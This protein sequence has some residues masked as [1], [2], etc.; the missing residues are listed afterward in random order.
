MILKICLVISITQNPLVETEEERVETNLNAA[1]AE[2]LRLLDA[3]I[4][5]PLDITLQTLGE[6]LEHGGASREHN[7]LVQ[8][9]TSVDGGALDHLVNDLWEG[10]E[11]VRAGNLGVEEDLRSEETLVANVH[12]EGLLLFSRQGNFEKLEEKRKR[13]RKEKKPSWSQTQLPRT[14]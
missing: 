8:T 10:S 12:S 7:V 9:T 4:N 14:A 5:G 3:V 2:D 13:K 6:I 11:E 1:T